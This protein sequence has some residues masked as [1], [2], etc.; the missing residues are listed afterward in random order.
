M[1]IMAR[2]TDYPELLESLRGKKVLIWTCNTCARLCNGI[3]GT[4]AS[5]RLAGKLSEGGIEIKGVV[6]TSASCLE[7]KVA[8]RKDDV[9]S[10]DADV[11]LSLTCSIGASVAA[12]VFGIETINP[13]VTFGYGFLT[14]EGVPMLVKDGDEVSVNTLSERASPFI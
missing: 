3:G 10:T 13:I 1:L 8:D 11:I 12:K 5:E 9:I 4:E 2:S 6:A 14:E 7:K